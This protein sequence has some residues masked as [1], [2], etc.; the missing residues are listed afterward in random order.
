[1][2]LLEKG[3]IVPV[4]AIRKM[5]DIEKNEM[6]YAIEIGDKMLSRECN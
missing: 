1:M 2:R 3:E 5:E 6:S 4:T